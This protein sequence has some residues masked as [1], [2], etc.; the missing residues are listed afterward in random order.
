M[1]ST[2]TP[3]EQKAFEK[4]FSM[5]RN[6]PTESPVKRKSSSMDKNNSPNA[7]VKSA[8]TG[9]KRRERSTPEFPA[10]LRPMAEEARVR[11]QA[12]RDAR[13]GI[14]DANHDGAIESMYDHTKAIMEAART[15][16]YLWKR[17][18]EHVLDR[19]AALELDPMTTEYQQD[20]VKTWQRLQRRLEYA[21]PTVS[22]AQKTSSDLTFMTANLPGLLLHFIDLMRTRFPASLLALNVLPSLKK[23]GPSV[24]ALGASTAL[25]NA[26]MRQLYEKYPLNVPAIVE[27]LTEMDREVYA[28]DDETLEIVED[29]IAEGTRCREGH[30][31]P[32]LRVVYHADT[33]VRAGRH[34]LKWREVMQ[35]RR[36]E[37]AL[38]VAREMYAEAEASGE[39]EDVGVHRRRPVQNDALGVRMLAGL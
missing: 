30:A 39:M 16:F 19:A 5:K 8:V 13:Q 26:H 11:E 29:V 12:A 22:A 27:V 35:Q 33:M 37:E 2:I 17:L 31:G 25:Y 10:S 7:I 38:R 32:A 14:A 34:L 18:K 9:H 21:L 20:A 4:L 36:E 23:L 15:D 28:F 1:K 24:F 6:Q 3:R